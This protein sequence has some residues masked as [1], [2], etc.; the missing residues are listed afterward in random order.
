MAK[1]KRVGKRFWVG[2][3]LGGTKLLTVVFNERFQVLTRIRKKHKAKTGANVGVKRIGDAIDEAMVAAGIQAT[4][5]RGIGMGAAGFL[6]LERGMILHAPNLGWRRVAIRRDL[7]FRFKVPVSLLNDVDA[8]TYGEYRLGAARR[9]RCVVGV[10]PGTGIGGACIVDGRLIRGRTGSAMEIGHICVQPGGNL[11]GCG[12]LGCLETVASRLAIAAQ[13]AA[14]AYRNDTPG[15]RQLT[16]TDVA[17]IR[18]GVIAGAL[19]AGDPVVDRIVRHAARQI[20][21][22][23]V[24]TLHLLMPDLILLGGGLVEEMPD[25]FIQEVR[26]TLKRH[27]IASFVKGVEVVAAALGDD[28][29]VKGAAAFA[30]DATRSGKG[31]AA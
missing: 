4:Q 8:G 26:D 20:G 22:A 7:A 30:S 21:A 15:L 31:G 25:L 28:A 27:A 10:F 14:A 16:G 23:L 9:A 2:C 29:V 5:V 1:K 13:I 11:C 18:S 3:D 24:S 12:R 19:R 6:D 17:E